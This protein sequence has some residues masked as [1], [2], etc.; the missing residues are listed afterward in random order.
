MGC[1]RI[2][3]TG[4]RYG[5]LTAIEYVGDKQYPCGKKLSAWK[6]ICD[7]G[8]ETV[9]L[10]SGLRSGKTRSCGCLEKKHR[11]EFGNTLIKHGDA[12]SRLYNIWI[13]MKMRCYNKNNPAYRYYGAKGVAV[14]DEWKNNYGAFRSWAIT[15]GYDESKKWRDCTIDRINPFGNYEPNNCRWIPMEEQYK[16]LRR[17][18]KGENSNG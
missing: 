15:N 10:L 3:I 12:H 14:C 6:C 4:E 16:N 5:L 13:M 1:V 7:C 9:V 8:N 2:D 17:Y 18:W 11:E